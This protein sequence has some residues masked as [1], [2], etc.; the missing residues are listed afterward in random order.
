MRIKGWG[1][2]GHLW[3][4]IFVIRREMCPSIQNFICFASYLQSSWKTPLLRIVEWHW[5]EAREMGFS[6]CTPWSH[7]LFGV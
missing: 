6:L 1:R 3:P 5:A 4:Q 2:D 7:L